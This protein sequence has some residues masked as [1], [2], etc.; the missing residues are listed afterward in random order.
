MLLWTPERSRPASD[1]SNFGKLLTPRKEPYAFML[2]MT[3]ETHGVRLERA[4]G[5]V[6]GL[7][8][9]RSGTEK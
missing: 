3:I 4:S 6:L 8:A 2:T 1:S 9:P 7:T 5:K